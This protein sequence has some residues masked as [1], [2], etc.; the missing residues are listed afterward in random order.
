MATVSDS[1]LYRK[2]GE[3]PH[4]GKYCN[5]NEKMGFEIIPVAK[6][7]KMYIL[8]RNGYFAMVDGFARE[9]GRHM[10]T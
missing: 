8:S 9:L 10:Y 1:A 7:D 5:F 6:W 2:R 4:G 3:D